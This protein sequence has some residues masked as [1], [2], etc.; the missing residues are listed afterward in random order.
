MFKLINSLEKN[1]FKF[2]RLSQSNRLLSDLKKYENS[3]L[4]ESLK[5]TQ[6]LKSSK[7]EQKKEKEKYQNKQT[8][9]K[10]FEDEER[11]LSRIYFF[12]EFFNRNIFKKDEKTFIAAIE[13]FSEH[14]K[15]KQLYIDFIYAAIQRMKEYNAH[16]NLDAYKKMLELFPVGPLRM[17]STWQREM[18]HFPR[19]QNCVIYLLEHMENNRN[20]F[21]IF[22]FFI[23]KFV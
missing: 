22:F 15:N 11:K 7:E 3:N 20:F 21:E 6:E 1:A 18:M 17:Q 4:D 23:M 13:A 12:D 14:N 19:H 16:K 8:N 5:E 2:I 10:Y 9:R